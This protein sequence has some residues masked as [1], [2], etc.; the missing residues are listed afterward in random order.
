MRLVLMKPASFSADM[1]NETNNLLRMRSMPHP[2]V[3]MMHPAFQQLMDGAGP[4]LC[5]GAMKG[6][7]RFV[8]MP[9]YNAHSAPADDHSNRNEP[10]N[11]IARK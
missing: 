5:S 2:N 10:A 11:R 6:G 7:T 4:L 3:A 8:V 9:F 1:E